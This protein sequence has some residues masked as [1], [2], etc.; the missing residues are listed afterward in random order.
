MGPV[1]IRD[2][3]R[4]HTRTSGY[5]LWSMRLSSF[6]RSQYRILL[7]S[8]SLSC[9][10]LTVTGISMMGRSDTTFWWI[11]PAKHQS[12]IGSKESFS[13]TSSTK[14]IIPVMKVREDPDSI[15]DL[16]AI[17]KGRRRGKVN[18]VWISAIG[19]WL[20]PQVSDQQ[21]MIRVPL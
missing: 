17:N 12:W 15:W 5:K 7:A 2:C 13:G 9:L 1:S 16:H 3:G 14:G 10:W 8:S 11:E 21:Q 6:S 20:T 4:F 19:L 18:D